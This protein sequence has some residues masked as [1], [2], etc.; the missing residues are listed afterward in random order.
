MHTY[1]AWHKGRT[2]EVKA[3]TSYGAQIKAADEFK[4]P[5]KRRREVSVLLVESG[6]K[7]VVHVADF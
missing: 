4:L 3:D 7:P 6:G 2:I 1:K 5:P